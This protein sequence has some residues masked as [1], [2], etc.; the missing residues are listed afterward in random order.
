MA[1]ARVKPMPG[2]RAKLAAV[3]VSGLTQPA[4]RIAVTDGGMQ[5]RDRVA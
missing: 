4:N 2:S 1:K 5:L 3:A